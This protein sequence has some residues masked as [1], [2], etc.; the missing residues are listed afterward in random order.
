MRDIVT[1]GDTKALPKYAHSVHIDV[2]GLD[3]NTEY[4]YQFKVGPH[5]SSVARTKTV[6]ADEAT[7]DEFNFAFASCQA[8]Y[9]E[10]YTAYKYMTEDDL[11]LIIY[12][13]D[14][15]YEY[16]IGS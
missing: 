10:F 1:R 9:E 3:A 2:Q 13:D 11:D 12:L 6:P 14:Y 15:I 16:G 8:W 4:Y 5:Y 7:V